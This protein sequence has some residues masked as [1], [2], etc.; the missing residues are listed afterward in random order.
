M[1]H[2]RL[3]GELC[4]EIS[5]PPHAPHPTPAPFLRESHKMLKIAPLWLYKKKRGVTETGNTCLTRHLL[6]KKRRLI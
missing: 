3:F 2:T 6:K 5:T 1:E 4:Y